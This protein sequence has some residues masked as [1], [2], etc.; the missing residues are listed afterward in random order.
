[1]SSRRGFALIGALW[2][3]VLLSGIALEFSLAARDIRAG[4]MNAHD[5]VMARAAAEAGIAHAHAALNLELRRAALRARQAGG[6][7][8]TWT[9]D[10]WGDLEPL[11]PDTLVMADQRTLV[12]LRDA[13]SLLNINLATEDEVRRFFVALRIDGREADRLS[14]SIADWRDSDDL[15]RARGAERDDYLEAGAPVLPG[16]GRFRDVRELRWVLGM[17]SNT[18]KRV[19]PWLTTVGS[20]RINLRTAGRPVLL[21]LPGMTEEAVAWIIR[22]RRDPWRPLDL[23]HLHSLLGSE[24]RAIMLPHLP[25]LIA[26]TVTVT[27]EVEVRSEGW[28]TA[29]RLMTEAS[30]LMVRAGEELIPGRVRFR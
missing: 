25:M 16:N 10:P 30:A 11:L 23:Q 15:H 4:T 27:M 13:G 2:F 3:V 24:A 18:Y 8:S 5:A 28:A 22:L 29:G 21:A 1:M 9:Q 6:A 14:Q 19:A 26:R 12:R 7:V 17:T 20:G